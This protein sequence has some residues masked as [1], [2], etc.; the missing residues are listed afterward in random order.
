VAIPL[1]AGLGVPLI[2]K[3]AIKE[4]LLSSLGADDVAESARLGRASY[5]VMFSLADQTE[6]MVLES[7]FGPESCARILAISSSPIQIYCRCEPDEAIRRYSERTSERHPGHF[8][9]EMLEDISERIRADEFAPLAL[10]G[11]T[12]E[13]DTTDQCDIDAVIAW[14]ESLPEWKT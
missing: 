10:P 6:A 13:L 3:D 4:A 7:N 2:R 8:D 5:E 11:P 1:A 12:L 9:E 14:V